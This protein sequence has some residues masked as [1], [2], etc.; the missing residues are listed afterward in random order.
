MRKSSI[1]P[2]NPGY[3]TTTRVK[4][5]LVVE[6][7]GANV[8]ETVKS[9]LTKVHRLY[10]AELMNPFKDIG[11]LIDSENFEREILKL[12]ASFNQTDGMI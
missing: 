9:L 5:F 10:V 3:V 2:S 11:K 8:D 4:L 1:S 7:D 6:D 12:F